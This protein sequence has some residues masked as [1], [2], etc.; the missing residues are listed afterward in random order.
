VIQASF[1]SGPFFTDDPAGLIKVLLTIVLPTASAIIA[2]VWKFMRGDLQSADARLQESL[3]RADAEIRRD[4]DGLG[5]RVSAT[6]LRQTELDDRIDDLRLSLT[7]AIH[8]AGR[9][10]GQ[11][12]TQLRERLA[13]IE[14]VAALVE[15][16]VMRHGAREHTR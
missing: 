3:Q 2:S 14:K 1:G 7:A 8:S 15:R 4:I 10:A 13:M 5:A 12:I 9:D 6:E 11:E 16:S